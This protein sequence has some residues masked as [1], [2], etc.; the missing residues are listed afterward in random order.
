M[1]GISAL[2][3]QWADCYMCLKG[4]ELD[5]INYMLDLHSS[6]FPVTCCIGFTVVEGDPIVKIYPKVRSKGMVI[7]Y[8]TGK[9]TN[10]E[11][12]D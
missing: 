5:T 11:D 2:P 10:V 7:D 1:T 3:G 8:Y 4:R 9:K 6:D 12:N